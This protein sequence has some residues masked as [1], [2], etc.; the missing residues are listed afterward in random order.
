MLSFAFSFLPLVSSSLY[1]ACRSC[2][3]PII[4]MSYH[5]RRCNNEKLPFRFGKRNLNG[6]ILKNLLIIVPPINESVTRCL[7]NE[8]ILTIHLYTISHFDILM[9][10]WAGTA[11]ASRT[12]ISFVSTTSAYVYSTLYCIQSQDFFL[13][14]DAINAG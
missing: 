9:V 14:H 12:L 5:E 10:D 4:K 7:S 3:Q 1:H 2:F 8:F 11:P 6:E 13:N